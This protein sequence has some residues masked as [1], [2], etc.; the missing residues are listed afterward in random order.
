MW[1]CCFLFRFDFV[2]KQGALREPVL[3]RVLFCL[4]FTWMPHLAKLRWH[5]PWLSP[6]RHRGR[7]RWRWAWHRWG[8][9]CSL[10]GPHS[11]R[12]SSV[13]RYSLR[14]CSLGP[15][16]FELA[17]LLLGALV[18]RWLQAR[19]SRFRAQRIHPF[20]KLQPWRLQIRITRFGAGNVLAWEAR[21]S[22][23]WWQLFLENQDQ[24]YTC[25]Q[26]ARQKA[27]FR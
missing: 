18:S 10:A 19:L 21:G 25:Q 23:A 9:R 17:V 12:G 4:G 27:D 26:C 2:V 1:F 15:P 6:Q 14:G 22:R 24:T 16:D 13:C 11:S 8:S 5:E 3:L 20:G 7:W